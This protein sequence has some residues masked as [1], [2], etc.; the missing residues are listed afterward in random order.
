MTSKTDL[1]LSQLEQ[2]LPTT[3]RDTEALRHARKAGHEDMSGFVR[4]MSRLKYPREALRHRGTHEG[5][6]PFE[7]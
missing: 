7:L 6:E 3:E 2:D 1:A 4:A 5:H